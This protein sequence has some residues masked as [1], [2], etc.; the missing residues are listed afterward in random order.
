MWHIPETALGD[1]FYSFFRCILTTRHQES[2]EMEHGCSQL[3]T[4][5]IPGKF[6]RPRWMSYTC[7]VPKCNTSKYPTSFNLRPRKPWEASEFTRI[8]RPMVVHTMLASH[9]GD[10]VFD[11]KMT[12]QISTSLMICKNLYTKSFI[13]PKE[14]AN[15]P[16]LAVFLFP[17]SWVLGSHIPSLP[18][19]TMF[20]RA[21]NLLFV[22]R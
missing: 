12:F 21:N 16:I 19:P 4:E 22:G 13:R 3:V 7:P 20:F 6:K 5:G 2:M 8:H 17:T 11:F 10:T 18:H 9:R 14:D 15:S 1:F